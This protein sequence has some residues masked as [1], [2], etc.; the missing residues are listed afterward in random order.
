MFFCLAQNG[1][2]EDGEVRLISIYEFLV[3][4]ID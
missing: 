3:R 4:T 2:P 1:L